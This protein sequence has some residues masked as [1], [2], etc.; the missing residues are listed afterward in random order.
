MESIQ[1]PS[2]ADTKPVPKKKARTKAVPPRN[3]PDPYANIPAGLLAVA[4]QPIARG[5]Y[6]L[7]VVG[8]VR[9]VTRARR[10]VQDAL[11]G[12]SDIPDDWAETLGTVFDASLLGPS[13]EV[14]RKAKA[15]SYQCPSCGEPI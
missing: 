4:R 12:V 13:D 8:N 10:M 2:T 15:L 1:A 5:G 3:K 9:S 6:D 7:G 14:K 11:A